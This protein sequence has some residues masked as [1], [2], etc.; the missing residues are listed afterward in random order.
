ML[1]LKEISEGGAA[2]KGRKNGRINNLHRWWAA[3]PTNVSRITAYAALVDPP[4]EPHRDAILEMCNYAKTTDPDKPAT[5][6]MMRRKLREAWKEPPKVLDPF[7]GAGALPFAASWLGCETYSMDYNPVAVLIQK[8]VLEY[9]SRYGRKLLYDVKRVAGEVEKE[10]REATRQFYPDGDMRP[11]DGSGRVYGHYAYKWCRIVPCGCG[12]T[13]PLVQSYALSKKDGIF[14]YPVIEDG[15]VRFGIAGGTEKRNYGKGPGGMVKVP[16][17]QITNKIATCVACGR[18]YTNIELRD[19]FN[20][21]EGSEKLMVAVTVNPQKPGRYYVVIDQDDVELYEKC[22]SELESRRTVF[23]A[24]YGIDPLPDGIIPQPDGKEYR[25]GGPTWHVQSV[26]TMGYTRWHHLFNTRQRLCIVILVDILRKTEAKLEQAHSADYTTAV[27]SYMAMIFDKT[28]EKCTRLSPW[29]SRD[30]VVRH[31]FP[32]QAL[33]NAWDYAEVGP[34]DIWNKSIRSVLEGLRASLA[35]E[36]ETIPDVRRASATNLREFG[37]D[38]FDVICTDPPYYD[39]MQYSKTA[40]FFYV[41]LKIVVGHRHTELFQ[42]ALSPKKNEVVET[43]GDAIGCKPGDYDGVR[44]DSDYQKLMTSALKE[45]HRVLKPN[46]ILTLVY[47]HKSLPGWETL[48]QSMLDAGFNITAAWPI[49]TESTSRMGA[50]KTASL[51]SS[52]YM[53]ARKW[54]KEPPAYYRAV[55]P[56]LREHVCA[57][58]D[59]FMEQGVNG[60]DFYIAAIGASCEVYGKYQTVLNDDGTEVKVSDMLHEIRGM[61]SEFI[62]KKLTTGGAGDMDSMSKLYV[63]WRWAYGDRPV[64]YDQARKMFTGVG[65]DV[66]SHMGDIVVKEDK[67]VRV[68]DAP[69]RKDIKIR[70]TIDVLHAALNL[71]SEQKMDEMRALLASYGKAGDP[72]FKSLCQAIIGAGDASDAH[73]ETKEKRVI[74]SFLL[75]RKDEAVVAP[76]G[77]LDRWQETP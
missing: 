60:A 24:E 19:M 68:L 2:E 5:R 55:R 14:L 9:P 77:T 69:S 21:G 62:V 44:G 16:K 49:D 47:A 29:Q 37:S 26:A 1:P 33:K 22:G 4:L 53:V 76:S 58:L 8:C 3:K 50:R 25:L 10:L 67:A 57:K 75:G 63:S 36:N 17:G 23:R 65:L 59:W 64:D 34:S 13:I 56:E 40:D 12:V 52:I 61:C 38:Y 66:D 43:A 32:Q 48:I 30:E 6:N 45:M 41:W 70:N 20:R 42:G 46:G 51:A 72:K 15:K 74:E 27:M 73:P 71:W 11:V 54:P 35:A 28:I 18:R 7:G 39:S 31:C